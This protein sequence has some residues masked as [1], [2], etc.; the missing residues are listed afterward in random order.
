MGYDIDQM[1]IFGVTPPAIRLRD[2][3][4]SLP[5]DPAVITQTKR[6][7]TRPDNVLTADDRRYLS[8]LSAVATED[9]R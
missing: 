5:R 4:I 2:V 3:Y 9:P 1:S 7:L 8:Q 6:L